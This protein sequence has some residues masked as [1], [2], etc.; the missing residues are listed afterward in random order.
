MAP[1]SDSAEPPEDVGLTVSPADVVYLIARAKEFAVK[2]AVTEPDPASNPSYDGMAE[3]LEDH[4]EDSAEQ[5]MAEF[6]SN[7]GEDEQIDL[8]ALAWLGRDDYSAEEWADVRRQATDAHNDKTARYLIGMPLLA[9]YLEAGLTSLGYSV[10]FIAVTLGRQQLFTET[11]LTAML[12]LLHYGTGL[13]NVVR[14]WVVVLAANLAGASIFAAASAFTTTFSPEL[15]RA[16]IEIGLE[17]VRYPFTT[18][19][20]KGVFGGWMIALSRALPRLPGEDVHWR[21][22][23]LLGAMVYTLMNPGRIQVITEHDADVMLI[24][25]YAGEERDPVLDAFVGSPFRK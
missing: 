14:L 20:V 8:V 23:V 1:V 18:A 25:S 2:D 17:Q 11:T 13:L 21:F 15:S 19:F 9:D 16:M 4:P 10:G 12:P 6:I 3:I 7:L 5:Q 22:H 24:I